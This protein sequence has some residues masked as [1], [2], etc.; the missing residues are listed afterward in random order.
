MVLS[1]KQKNI[2]RYKLRQDSVITFY[3]IVLGQLINL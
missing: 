3:L 1:E 2:R